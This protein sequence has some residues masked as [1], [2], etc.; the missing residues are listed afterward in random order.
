MK[1]RLT[2]YIGDRAFYKMALAIII[3]V[4]VQQ[5]ILS[6]AGYVDNLM[7]NSFSQEAYIGVSTANRFMFLVNFFWIG[8]AAGISVFIA[9]YF[10]A[11]DKKRVTA[12]I[13]L[14]LII[15]LFIGALSIFLIKYLGPVVIKFFIIEGNAQELQAISHGIEYL[16]YI[17]LGAVIML[18]NFMVATIYRSL[19]KP[20]VPM[21]AGVLG[22]V[23]NI[24]LNFILIFGL[25]GFPAMG[26]KG[27]AIATVISKVVELVVLIVVAVFYDT[28]KYIQAI[29]KGYFIDRHLFGL[30]LKKGLPIIM[31]E[32]LWATG[33]QI[34]ARL[35]T[36]GNTDWLLAFNYSQNLTDLFFIYFGGIATGTAILVGT[37][38]GEGDFAKAR[39]YANKLIGI[40]LMAS[41]VAVI[42]LVSISPALLLI[43][44][45]VNEIYFMTYHLILVTSIFVVIYGFN[46]VIFFILRAGGDSFRAF[47]LDQVPT[48][49]IGIPLAFLLH[50]MEPKWQLGLV[51]IFAATRIVDVTKA[52]V[53]TKF[54]KNET[55]VQN[56]TALT[57]ITVPEFHSKDSEL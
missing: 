14:S 50:Q 32:V 29:F 30:Y 38:L 56:L 3:P 51:F 8:L 39:D 16:N 21:Y 27:A 18:L 23:V 53:A 44:T 12:T 47:L 26:A 43:L 5:L 11:K 17:A 49:T 52:F 22:I 40:A 31:N 36:G 28:E 6:I 9:Q 41:V 7:I 24:I 57:P 1:Q 19:G 20:K 46:A 33:V 15:A 10:G 54:Y 2:K 48:F 13:Q 35:I 34:L 45:P 25:L 37:A 55:W 4:V 42:L